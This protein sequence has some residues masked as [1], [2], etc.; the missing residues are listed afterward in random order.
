VPWRVCG[1]TLSG[2]GIV[3][4]M[5]PV[6]TVARAPSAAS[7]MWGR[8][9]RRSARRCPR[10]AVWP[11][12]SGV[13]LFGTGQLRRRRGAG[14]VGFPGLSGAPR[15]LGPWPWGVRHVTE[16]AIRDNRGVLAPPGSVMESGST[17]RRVRLLHS[18]VDGV[19][20]LGC[21]SGS[22]K[23]RNAPGVGV[24]Y[25]AAR[26]W[27]SKVWSRIGRGGLVPTARP[28]SLRCCRAHGRVAV[29]ALVWTL[30]RWRVPSANLGQEPGTIR[31]EARWPR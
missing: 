20:I 30:G 7:R 25:E 10:R 5:S 29:A 26:R 11:L 16:R 13:S 17:A 21:G 14:A 2:C 6:R 22:V 1:A 18:V 24:S 31:A 9:S 4:L 3:A 8:G 28:R 19:P 23:R 15:R 12:L 27:E